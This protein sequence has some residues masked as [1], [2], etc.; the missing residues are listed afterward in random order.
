MTA[1]RTQEPRAELARETDGDLLV[2]MTLAPDDP[3]AAR[4]AWEEFYRRHVNY[5]YAVCLRAYGRPLG[6]Q[7][8]VADLVADTFKRAYE[9][10]EKFDA[11]GITDPE[12]LRGRTR[13]WLGRIAQ[14]L[15]QD[16]LRRRSRLPTRL[17][18]R[19]SHLWRL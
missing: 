17:Q 16:A 14:R 1:D 8:A 6:G 5:L 9:N 2:Y 3:P 4:A 12:R 11:D 10:A 15:A 7:P 19:P 18:W 13:G